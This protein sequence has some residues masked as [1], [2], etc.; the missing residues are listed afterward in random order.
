MRAQPCQTLHRAGIEIVNRKGITLRY[1]AFS[2]RSPGIA[3]T[4][5]TDG[6]H[7]FSLNHMTT[8]LFRLAR[9]FECFLDDLLQR[10]PP[11]RVIVFVGVDHEVAHA[12]LRHILRGEV[13]F[14][15]IHP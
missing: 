12:L 13:I 7:R 9:L 4:N 3:E 11:S 14:R 10:L 1:N 6:W 8:T 2:N 5:Q 15:Y